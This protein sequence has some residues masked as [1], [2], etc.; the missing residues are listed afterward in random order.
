MPPNAKGGKNY[1]KKKHSNENEVVRFIEKEEDQ[2]Y[3]RVIRMLGGNNITAYCNDDKLRLCH[4]RGSM[5]KRVWLNPGDIVLVSLRDSVDEKGDVV[6]K[7]DPSLLGKLKK[8]E[9]INPRLFLALESEGGVVIKKEDGIEFEI[10]EGQEE[11][12]EG[13]S[14][15]SDSKIDAI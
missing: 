3:A 7:Y 9:D 13:N 14:E 8:L 1:K 10:T 12:E 6:M 4:I 2:L 11:S 5:R 15:M